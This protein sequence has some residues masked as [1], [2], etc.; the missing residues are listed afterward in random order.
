MFELLNGALSGMQAGP[1]PLA[2]ALVA[3]AMLN[4]LADVPIELLREHL[5]NAAAGDDVVTVFRRALA[6]WDNEESAWALSVERNSRERRDLIYEKLALDDDWIV[7]CELKFPFHRVNPPIVIAREHIAWY[8]EKVR[9]PRSFYWNAYVGQLRLQSWSEESIAQL[10][11]S[12]T[13]I[14]ERLADPTSEAAY[15]SK[16]L[17]VGYVQ[18]GKTANFTGVIAKAAD[19]GYKLIIVLAGTLDVLRSQTQRRIDKDLIGQELLD[20]SYENDA[21]WDRFLKHGAP[22]GQ[23]GSFDFHRLTGRDDDYRR[24]NAGLEAL[25]FEAAEKSKPLY[26]K[27]NLFRARTRIAIVKKNPN[28]LKR[29]LEDLR[30]T[31]NLGHIAPLDQIPTLIIDDES[32]QAGINVT[33][34][35]ADGEL[36][37]RTATNLWQVIEGKAAINITLDPNMRARLNLKIP[38]LLGRVELPRHGALDFTQG[39]VMALDQV[40]IIAVHDAYGIGQRG[41]RTRMQ[42]GSKPATGGRE[43]RY[44]IDDCR[45]RLLKQAWFNS[46]GCF[47]RNAHADL[48]A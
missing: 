31:R 37:N 1:K 27:E 18:S 38:A 12:T 2:K 15:Q 6:G 14:V 34:P 22:P 40:G 10:D 5:A 29:L 43:R 28:I 9:A 45:I 46:A 25:Q 30:R 17:V 16:G 8:D 20:D 3:S 26:N 13:S 48:L 39:C 32:D 23:L 42:P 36:E 47:D 41:S 11:N 19:A 7:L 4:D 33:R 35:N 44:Q 21:D 24:L